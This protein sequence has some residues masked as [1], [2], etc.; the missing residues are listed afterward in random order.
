MKIFNKKKNRQQ[1]LSLIEVVIATSIIV[2]AF[3][4]LVSIYNTYLSRTKTNIQNL[5]AVYLAEEGV[6][7]V[8]FLRDQSWTTNIVPL[9]TNTNYYFDFSGG[10]FKSTTTNQFI[11]GLYERKFVLQNVNRDIN[12]DIVTSGGTTDSGTRLLTVSISWAYKGA[13]TTKSISTY[14]TNIFGN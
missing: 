10:D 11:D 4:S 7:A 5:K 14:I 9:S 12:D 1:G 3:L 13:T 6:E 8:K 2:A